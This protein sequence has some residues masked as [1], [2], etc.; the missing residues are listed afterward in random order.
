MHR[1][2]GISVLQQKGH[3]VSHFSIKF[4]PNLQ[5]SF[6][7]VREFHA[8]I[9]KIEKNSASELQALHQAVIADLMHIKKYKEY[10]EVALKSNSQ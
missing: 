8:S 4:Y 1:G 7:Y 6:R 3:L 9:L 2:P 10:W 5:S